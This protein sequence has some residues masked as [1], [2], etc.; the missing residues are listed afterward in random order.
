MQKNPQRGW[1]DTLTWMELAFQ[2]GRAV[3]AAQTI[4]CLR[5]PTCTEQNVLLGK[6][7]SSLAVISFTAATGMGHYLLTK[8]FARKNRDTAKLFAGLS[9]AGTGLLITLNYREMK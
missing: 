3:E 5:R 8:R 1:S 9:L 7:P 2:A 6:R 4:T